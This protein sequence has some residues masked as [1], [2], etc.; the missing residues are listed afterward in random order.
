MVTILLKDAVHGNVMTRLGKTIGYKAAT[1]VHRILTFHTVKVA[2]AS[3]LKVSLSFAGDTKGSFA[4]ELQKNYPISIIRQR[5]GNLGQKIHQALQISE[6]SIAI[7]IDCPGVT[8]EDLQTAATASNVIFGPSYD[9]GY[10]LIG[11]NNPAIELFAD[12]PWS[13]PSVLQK[14]INNCKKLSLDYGFLPTRYDIDTYN[15]LHRLLADPTLPSSLKQRLYPY[16]RNK[17]AP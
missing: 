15:D 9:G 2:V 4:Q 5:N 16:A 7:G 14:S 6:R 11:A 8:I 3:G 12:V 17:N 13:T 10:W 1:E